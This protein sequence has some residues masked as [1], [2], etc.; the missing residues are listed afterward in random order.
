MTW[1]HNLKYETIMLMHYNIK[2]T[3]KW[4]LN[5]MD[6][7]LFE[8]RYNHQSHWTLCHLRIPYMP[9]YV[10]R[11]L[12]IWLITICLCCAV[13]PFSFLGRINK[14]SVFPLS[15]GIVQSLELISSLAALQTVVS[16]H[17]FFHR[18][19]TFSEPFSHSAWLTQSPPCAW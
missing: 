7:A 17:I 10:L 16:E 19:F 3:F 13:I 15:S 8:V 9:F 5:E 18:S 4:N 11:Q 2:N 1:S 14:F 12:N 6:C